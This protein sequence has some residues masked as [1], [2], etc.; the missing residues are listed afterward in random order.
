VSTL[1]GVSGENLR[2][3]L[4]QDV[5]IWHIMDMATGSKQVTQTTIELAA[6]LRERIGRLNMSNAEIARQADI[7]PSTLSRLLRG[8]RPFYAEDLE[9]VCE[10]LGLDLGDVMA[11]AKTVTLAA[12]EGAGF[13]GTPAE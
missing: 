13:P 5:P 12:D 1:H 4:Y 6:I 11:R 8:V 7:D 3:R 9:R 2:A 10:A